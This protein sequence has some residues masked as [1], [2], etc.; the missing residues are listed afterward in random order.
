MLCAFNEFP[1]AS[2]WGDALGKEVMQKLLSGPSFPEACFSHFYTH[3]LV[4]QT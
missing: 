4:A 1:K 2:Y 3:F